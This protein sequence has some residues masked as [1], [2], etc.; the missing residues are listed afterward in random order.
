MCWGSFV[1]K[2]IEFSGVFVVLYHGRKVLLV[3]HHDLTDAHWDP[4]LLHHYTT[5]KHTFD[6]LQYVYGNIVATQALAWV[7]THTSRHT[8]VL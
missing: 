2:N 6:V 1:W 4:C 3:F 8:L 5:L 7:S